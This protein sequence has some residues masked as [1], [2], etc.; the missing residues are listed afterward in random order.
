VAPLPAPVTAAAPAERLFV[1]SGCGGC[2]TLSGVAGATGVAGP[3][4]TNVSLRPT[5]AGNTIPNTPETLARFLLEPAS[6]APDTRMPSVG[7]T[8]HEAQQLAAF[9]FGLPNA[10]R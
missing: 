4:L 6:V 3:N 2:H 8:P 7:L 1:D 10:R 5:L 9:L